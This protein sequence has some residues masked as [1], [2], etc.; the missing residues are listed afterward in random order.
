M[1]VYQ[2]TVDP[3]ERNTSHALMLDLVGSDRAVLDV[4]CASGYL[5]EALGKQG[6]LVSGVEYDAVEAEKARPFL[7]Q[8]VVADLNQVE[9][10]EQFPGADFD[11]IVFGDVLEHLLEPASVLESALSLL[12]PDGTVVI[13][14]PNVAHGAVRLTLLQGRW[15][16]RPTG[17]LDRTHIRFFTLETLLAML[18][19]AGLL[20]TDLRATVA[21]ALGTEIAIDGETL[22]PFAVDWVRSQ[23]RASD[24]QYILAA[25]RGTPDPTDAAPEVQPA[26]TLDPVEDVHAQLARDREEQRQLIEHQRQEILA[27]RRDMLTS[28][29]HAVGTEA[30][31]GQLRAELARSRDETAAVRADAIYAHAELAKS[32]ADAQR[33][34]ATLNRSFTRRL[35]NRSK[36]AVATLVGPRIWSAVTVSIRRARGTLDDNR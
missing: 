2:A 12:R 32:I 13:S 4:G 34:H 24:Y 21:D 9:L 18:A 17:L 6:C 5:A 3:A 16:Y 25:R 15:D 19:D 30:Q 23:P 1:S 8:L 10:G 36:R 28:R 22:P 7:E 29:D 20:V 26:I 31:L 35:F 27:L 14:I 33:A 11:V